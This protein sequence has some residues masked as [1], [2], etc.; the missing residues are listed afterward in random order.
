MRLLA[1][2]PHVTPT[3]YEAW[4]RCRRLFALAHLLAVPASDEQP[5]AD[6]G[7]LVHDIL[8][9]IHEQGSVHDPGHVDDVLAAHGADDDH[10]RALVARHARRV[11]S[12]FERAAHEVTLA[13]FHRRPPPM[14]MATARIDATW[15]HDG[16]LDARDY[17]TGSVW[18]SRV[19]DDPRAHVQAW[20]L[21]PQARRRGLRLRL[22]YEHLAAEV[23]DEPEPWEPD[24]DDLVAVGEA[25]REFVAELWRRA[26]DDD[27]RGV[28]EPDTCLRCRY[29]SI[30]VDS[31]AP[32]EPAWPALSVSDPGLDAP[33]DGLDD[34]P[35]DGSGGGPAVP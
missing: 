33:D 31:A 24:G 4:H 8:R 11:P 32:A 2:I 35:G 25:L 21:A 13:R 22:R 19:A 16:L 28:G 1:D 20:V 3:A 23:V 10:Y 7:L 6:E 14:F 17:K 18:Y 29:R 15:V 27:W 9:M 26:G 12:R 5:S 34:S 30:C